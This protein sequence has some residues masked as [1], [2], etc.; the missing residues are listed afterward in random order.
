MQNANNARDIAAKIR[1]DP[2]L[3]IKQQQQA[4]F[5]AL[6][7]NP[8]RLQ[9]MQRRNGIKPKKDK[10]ERKRDKEER[11]RLKAERKRMRDASY[12]RS[13]RPRNERSCRSPSPDRHSRRRDSRSP[14]DRRPSPLRSDER[15]RSSRGR[16]SRDNYSP[17]RRRD[18]SDSPPPRRRDRSDSPNYRRREDVQN[19]RLPTNDHRRRSR[20]RSLDR[21]YD[22]SKHSRPSP[23]RDD[24]RSSK[25][26]RLSP[27]SESKS[28]S[29]LEDDRAARLAAMS[30]NATVVNTERQKRLAELLEKEKAQLAADEAAR[31]Q[32]KG[33]GQFLSQEQK[34][35]F[36]GTG[37][38]EDRIRRGRGGLV[39]DAD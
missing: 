18:R 33:V 28:S 24:Y 39:V 8:L 26:L 9:E 20:S 4:A 7:A 32:S 25:R 23:S 22:Q 5:E 2:L 16:S 29:R 38:L 34:K 27:P 12:S 13:P 6:M 17:P 36:G 3:A 11:K 35:V 14:F 21:S 31:A 1:E 15:T 10:A 37:G 19:H 30:V